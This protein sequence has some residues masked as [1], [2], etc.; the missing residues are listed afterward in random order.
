[1]QQPLDGGRRATRGEGRPRPRRVD[2]AAQ[3]PRPRCR[4]RRCFGG[5]K[6]GWIWPPAA[7]IVAPVLVPPNAALAHGSFCAMGKGGDAMGKVGEREREIKKSEKDD[8]SGTLP[9]SELLEWGTVRPPSDSSAGGIGWKL[10]S[11]M[12]GSVV[13]SR[14]GRAPRWRWNK[15]GLYRFEPSRSVIPY[16]CVWWFFRA[17]KVSE[18]PVYKLELAPT[19][20][21]WIPLLARHWPPFILQEVTTCA[22]KAT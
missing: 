9:E 22:A 21:P 3:P 18:S 11:W 19:F 5:G 8:T 6:E 17:F 16:S 2:L 14:G 10:R 1:M 4:R 20:D 13:C 7:A 12:E 15:R